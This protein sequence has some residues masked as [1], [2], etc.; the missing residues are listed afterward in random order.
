MKMASDASFADSSTAR[1]FG[2]GM[3]H[4]GDLFEQEAGCLRVE[5]PEAVEVRIVDWSRW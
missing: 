3:H 5:D 1:Q 4:A 2:F